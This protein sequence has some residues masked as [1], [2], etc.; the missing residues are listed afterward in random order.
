MR[1]VREVSDLL[2][3]QPSD[4]LD[5]VCV[6]EEIERAQPIEAIAPLLE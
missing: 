1:A 3:D 6:W 4:G 2:L 5:V